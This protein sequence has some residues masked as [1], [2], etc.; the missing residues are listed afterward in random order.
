VA[1]IPLALLCGCRKN[2][3][4]T[5]A[6]PDENPGLPAT[7]SVAPEATSDG[8]RTSTPGAEGVDEKPL[9][10]LLQSIRDGAVETQLPGAGR[11]RGQHLRLGQWRQFH[12]P[13][14]ADQLVVVITGSNY[15][16]VTEDSGFFIL[17]TAALP[18]VQ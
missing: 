18:A 3:A 13:V 9:L 12:L 15:S 8:R 17:T 14:S 5:L 1:L 7:L 10:E 16:M 4:H 11:L 2:Y 6:K